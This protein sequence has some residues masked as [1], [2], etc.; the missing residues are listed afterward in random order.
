MKRTV[1]GVVAAIILS[2]GVCMSAGAES[3]D[4]ER[5]QLGNSSQ[6]LLNGGILSEEEVVVG[7]SGY[8]GLNV[9]EDH[10]YYVLQDRK[11]CKTDRKTGKKSVLYTTQG[12]I[13]ELCVV[14]DR[15]VYFLENGNVCSFDQNDAKVTV[16]SR[17]GDVKGM[18]PTPYGILFA[19]GEVFEWELSAGDDKI[20]DEVYQYYTEEGHLVYTKDH[21]QYQIRL[22]R[23]F[24]EDF[25]SDDIEA[26]SLGESTEALLETY[27]HTEDGVCEECE[28]NAK[29][30]S[31]E[32]YEESLKAAPGIT[33]PGEIS[34]Y[35]VSELS[36]AQYTMIERAEAQATVA[37]TPLADVKGWN[38]NWT[39]KK[40]SSYNGIPYGQPVYASYVP[41]T[42]D[43][44]GFKNAVNNPN[45][46]FYTERSTY[47]KSAPYYSSD[48]SSFV[49]W[50][51]GLSRNT[52]RTLAKHGTVLSGG[53]YTLQVGD[54][55]LYE[56]SHVKLVED[57]VY[58]NGKMTSVT[59]I[60]Q[61]PPIILRTV[62]GGSSRKTLADLNN[63]IKQEGTTGKYIICRKKGIE[64]N[65]G[66]SGV[67]PALGEYVDVKETDW[68]YEYVK[69]VS[70]E[71]IM[72]G[73]S[74][75]VFAPMENLARAQLAIIVHRM[76]GSPEVEYEQKFNDV[77]D[78]Q[79]Y[80]DAITWASEFGVITGYENGDFGP[81]D[82]INREQLATMLYR[83][84]E[85]QGYKTNIF[86]YEDEY[87]D[88]DEISDFSLDAVRWCLGQ[89]IISG[90]GGMLNPKGEVNRAVAAT[91]I[92][93]FLEC[94]EK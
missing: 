52:T 31:E 76:H 43:L 57:V 80:S 29:N 87:P 59:I 33:A 49:S 6:N 60:E 25:S 20:L 55:L 2:A 13:E 46:K 73:V 74:E 45:S 62:Y 35:A 41:Y 67:L 18:I 91:M 7:E 72:T 44:N 19:R 28:K 22:E 11:I 24:A 4:G 3:F 8:S 85:K 93:R 53:V 54:I 92:T 27:A 40:G 86:K 81:A 42:T 82:V 94:A 30:F 58:T 64:Q 70:D 65:N 88:K 12:T 79:F 63:E 32:L 78:G 71:G 75:G 48:C 21:K 77:T 23:L 89:D 16:I 50:A 14:N 68:F 38:D 37:W 47:N 90:D 83:Y 26:Y 51:W 66:S 9:F 36:A 61:T 10:I 34:A 5:F 84:A 17:T 15:E 1:I 69:N 39:F 56:G